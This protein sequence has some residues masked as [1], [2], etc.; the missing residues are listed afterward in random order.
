[1]ITITVWLLISLNTSSY[2]Q[3][4]ITLIERFYTAAECQRVSE[5]IR[6][7]SGVS[8]T[9]CIQAEVVKP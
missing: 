4:P 9:K 6:V 2:P 5:V 8:I 7:A 3:R 1:M